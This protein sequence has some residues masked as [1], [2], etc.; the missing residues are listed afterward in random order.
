MIGASKDGQIR[1]WL[2]KLRLCARYPSISCTKWRGAASGYIM[3]GWNRQFM[4]QETF[5]NN[6]QTNQS[7]NTFA[8]VDDY[9]ILVDNLR[10]VVHFYK[11][12]GEWGGLVRSVPIENWSGDWLIRT[13]GRFFLLNYQ[14]SDDKVIA[15]VQRN[16]YLTVHLE[17]R[18]AG[19]V[20]Y[21]RAL[22]NEFWDYCVS[23][24]GELGFGLTVRAAITD[25]R[26][27]LD[28]RTNVEKVEITLKLG[29]S[30]R[31]AQQQLDAFWVA[32]GLLPG[33]RHTRQHLRQAVLRQ[34]KMNCSQFRNQLAY[35]DIRINCK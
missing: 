4:E 18:I 23:Y 1:K 9:R 12:R 19:A 28:T 6:L 35:F 26:G 32:N 2:L 30:G 29:S 14:L 31:F 8:V 3:L 7:S 16:E 11:G 33:S 5:L 20:L 15:S 22:K 10:A 25:L 21:K 17:H 27:K 24:R 34:R 13:I